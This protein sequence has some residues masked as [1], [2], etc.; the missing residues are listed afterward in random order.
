MKNNNI[1]IF[2]IQIV[3][4]KELQGKMKKSLVKPLVTDNKII[5]LL[6]QDHLN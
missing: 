4:E 5:K 1:I 6:I 2:T 3:S